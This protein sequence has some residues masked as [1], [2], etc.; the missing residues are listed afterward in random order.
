MAE[1]A[2]NLRIV[3]ASRKD[4]PELQLLM[5]QSI[6][7]LQAPFLTKAQIKASFE[8]MGLDSQLIEDGTYFAVYIQDVLAGCGGWSMRATL[9]G[10]DH[11][12]GR[13]AR[14]LDPSREPA[15][16][17]AMYTHPDFVRLGVGRLVLLTC[18]QAAR[19]AGFKRAEMM[20]TLAGVPL[21]EACGYAKI[22]DV[23]D[24]TSDGT[25]VPLVRMGKSLGLSP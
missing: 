16:I 1:C 20:A 5:R 12:K 14:W 18:E 8:V 17:R 23:F 24:I 9:Y 15:R 19:D 10:G 2:K 11:S 21:Y 4:L 7:T 6:K 3:K 25:K 13:N 22:E